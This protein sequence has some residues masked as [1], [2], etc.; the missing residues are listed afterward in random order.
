M[1]SAP[2]GFFGGSFVWRCLDHHHHSRTHAFLPWTILRFGCLKSLPPRISCGEFWKDAAMHLAHCLLGSWMCCP[3]TLSR[4]IQASF[5][6]FLLLI[7]LVEIFIYSNR[8]VKGLM[9]NSGQSAYSASFVK[10]GRIVGCGCGVRELA[11]Q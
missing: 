8:R 7:H 6:L 9:A 4:C 10:L 11:L 5:F 2:T 1:D 3:W